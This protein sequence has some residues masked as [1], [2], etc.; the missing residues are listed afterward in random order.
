MTY[1]AK[2]SAVIS[3]LDSDGADSE[4]EWAENILRSIGITPETP[5]GIVTITMPTVPEYFR[6]RAETDHNQ[7]SI[8][9]NA[10]RQV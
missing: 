8:E 2:V 4:R 5:D 6:P 9:T 10:E 7:D 1:E 3:K